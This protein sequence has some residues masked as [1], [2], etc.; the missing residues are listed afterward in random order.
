MRVVSLLFALLVNAIPLYGVHNLGWSA[1]TV[2][3]L[4]W[5]ENLAIAVFTCARIAL[6]RKLTRKRGHWRGGTMGVKV[7]DKLVTSGLLGEYAVMAFVFTL[8]HGVFVA[9]FVFIGAS[10]HGD[11][12][13]WQF[14]R[15]QF[16]LGLQW[17][18]V[19]LVLEFLLDA[20]TL[21]SRSFAWIKAYVGQRTGRVLIMHFVIIIGMFAMMATESP[22]AML[23]VLIAL[24][25]LWDVF[26]STASGRPQALPTEPPGWVASLADKTAKGKHGAQ[27]MQREWTRNRDNM[28]RAAQEDE[29]VMPA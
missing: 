6:H 19:A 25:T 20:A 23:Y 22:F 29:E 4:Y 2:I 9:A 27:E 24:K 17:L 16:T 28:I 26:A 1:S 21:R 8:A 3:A 12:P 5:V 10:N 15:E 18:L 14:S 7:N 13:A 11:S